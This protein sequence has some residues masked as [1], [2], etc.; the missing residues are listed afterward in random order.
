MDPE[1]DTCR[2]WQF[3]SDGSVT[4]FELTQLNKDTWLLTGSGSG[5]KGNSRYRS[6][7]TRTG[8]D[9]TKE[10]MLEYVLD[11]K[12]KPTTVRTWKRT[13]Q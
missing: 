7:V 9:S 5:P 6:R 11:G 2:L 10:E 1:S 3:G 12:P 8:P 13:E 4:V